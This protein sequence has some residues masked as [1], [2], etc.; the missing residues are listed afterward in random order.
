[1]IFDA[2]CNRFGFDP[3]LRRAY[4]KKVRRYLRQVQPGLSIQG[5]D[6]PG[7]TPLK[8]TVAASVTLTAG[9]EVTIGTFAQLVG[10]PGNDYI[11][12]IMG[13]CSLLMGGTA[14][15]AVV[16][17]ALYTG[18][19]DYTTQTVDVN[20]LVNSQPVEVNVMLV[21]ANV[22][23]ASNGNIGTTTIAFT[24]AA[25]TTACTAKGPGCQ[26]YLFAYPGGDL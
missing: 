24:G 7:I 8:L 9:A 2:I 10:V 11:P 4:A 6:N 19:A 16:L 1:M 17:A 21:G 23:A 26:L 12:I 14:S 20:A 18:G 25:T 22:R 5:I 15:A 13:N 3:Q